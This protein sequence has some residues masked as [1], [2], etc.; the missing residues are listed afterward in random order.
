MPPQVKVGMISE[1]SAANA[2]YDAVVEASNVK[3][4]EE[5][6]LLG[7]NPSEHGVRH[8]PQLL[9][10]YEVC[11]DVSVKKARPKRSPKK[12]VVA[13]GEAP[14]LRYI[15]QFNAI[16][17]CIPTHKEEPKEDE[18]KEEEPKE[19]EPKEAPKED[20]PKKNVK[21]VEL[22][23]CVNGGKKIT[24]RTLK[25]SHAAVFPASENTPHAK[26]RKKEEATTPDPRHDACHDESKQ[27]QVVRLRTRQEQFNTWVANAI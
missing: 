3:Q 11:Q 8:E 15:D 16:E 19:Q 2:A 26:S 10:N 21:I 9:D 18:P 20:G 24:A 12:K 7:C 25:Y 1:P 17:C 4:E 23:E 27:P 5:E 14:T 13:V 22:S 6:D